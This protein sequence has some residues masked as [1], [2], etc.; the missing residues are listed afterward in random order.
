MCLALLPGG[1]LGQTIPDNSS[2]DFVID[3][4][5]RNAAITG[6]TTDGSAVIG[7]IADTSGLSAGDSI[8]GAGI[9]G[10]ANIVS[11]DSASQITISDAATATGTATTLNT[12]PP[13]VPTNT[14]LND[15]HS[16]EI[17][18]TMHRIID[19]G[20]GTLRVGS[21]GFIR[22]TPTNKDSVTVNGGSLTAGGA[23]NTAGT[24]TLQS[25]GDSG[26]RDHRW[27]SL[28]INADIVD[29]GSGAVSVTKR[30]N[31]IT[32]LSGNNTYS[33]GTTVLDGS[34]A[35]GGGYLRV[36][37]PN[38]LGPGD[39]TVEG[40]GTDTDG[41]VHLDGAGV[42]NNDFYISGRGSDMYKLGR[43]VRGA[44]WLD[45]NAEVAGTVTLTNDS[46]IT[47]A[48]SDSVEIS[49]K[50]TGDYDLT[51]G[52][53]HSNR[54][55]GTVTLSNTNNDWGGDTILRQNSTSTSSR[56][57]SLQ[58]GDSEVI[59]HGAGKGNL[60]FLVSGDG[61]CRLALNGFSETINGLSS[62]SRH[63]NRRLIYS[64][65]A[66]EVTFT[67]GAGDADGVFYGQIQD[68]SGTVNVTKT[69][70]GTQILDSG[71]Y[72]YSGATDVQGGTLDMQ[73]TLTGTSGVTVHS[74]AAFHY[75]N[76]NALDRDVT[77]DGGT[78]R[79]TSTADYAGALTHNSGE[80]EGT[81]W[82][83]SLSGLTI[84]AGQTV[85][86][87]TSPGAAVTSS[88]TWAP[89]GTFEFEINNPDGTAG[90]NWD[91][92]TVSDSLDISG[93]SPA[94]PFTISLVSL[95]AADDPGVLAGFDPEADYEWE[96]ASYGTLGGTFSA[97]LFD[98]E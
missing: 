76:D 61:W 11:V 71:V 38:S 23:D 58:L 44:I 79:H 95:T 62:N 25:N 93:L 54:D 18:D 64:T 29:N 82:E 51:F 72:S 80:L 45:A 36:A 26:T 8:T 21:D 55:Q 78:F 48:P 16:I 52:N 86:P 89:G 73:G 84:G 3:S 97:D 94:N 90:V 75:S 77:L 34:G 57:L 67:M 37:G 20:T 4:S 1:A 50:I 47:G 53:R 15:I 56:F 60:N 35:A 49:G 66:G 40:T 6:N 24:L 91:H 88:Q 27:Q 74:G 5:T 12:A 17:T 83:G 81:N 68:G 65:A 22:R 39:V 33:G 70:S 96:F 32:V 92:L 28:H 46:R 41:G 19:I 69:G 7:G 9:P 87:G 59:P 42:Y 85:A 14:T 13:A 43:D 30:G 2:T 98:I 10:R 31:F 63:P